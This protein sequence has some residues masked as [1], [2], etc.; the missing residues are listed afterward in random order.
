MRAFLLLLSMFRSKYVVGYLAVMAAVF[1]IWQ[2]PYE[3]KWGDARKQVIAWDVAGYYAYLPMMFIED[4]LQLEKPWAYDVSQI[5]LGFPEHPSGSGRHQKFTMGMAYLYAPFFAGAHTYALATNP[6]EAHGFSKPYQIGIGLA[7][8]LYPLLGLVL[9][10][11][12]LRHYVPDAAI[13][14]ALAAVF[15]GTNLFYYATYRGAMS[16]GATFMLGAAMLYQADL[17]RRRET[18]WRLLLLG[19]IAGLI[20]L[21]RPVNIWIP[22]AVGAMFALDGRLPR[23]LLTPKRLSAAVAVAVAVGLPQ[24]MYWKASTG[25]WLVWSYGEEGFFW[26]DPA[27]IQGL[28]SW[29]K[30]W[31]LYTPIASLMIFGFWGLARKKPTWALILGLYLILHAYVTFSWWTWWYGGGFG[32]RPMIDAYALLVLPLAVWAQRML[33]HPA[34]WWRNMNLALVVLLIGWN[35]VQTLQYSN[36]FLHYDAMSKD[37]YLYLMQHW[38]FVPNALLD[39]PDYEAALQGRAPRY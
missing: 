38:D 10:R 13:S 18:P 30:G 11:R 39:Q 29:R 8:L 25:H 20:V 5:A 19:G 23:G 26:K 9:L 37:A 32:S 22:L 6:S 21:I 33:E 28:F 36:E 1:F 34:V 31:L 14:W 16:H 2:K 7:G 35:L 3:A 12:T 4:D 17:W 15:L 27:W 24:L